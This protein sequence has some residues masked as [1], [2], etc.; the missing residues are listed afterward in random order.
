MV[1]PSFCAL[2]SSVWSS[3]GVG[4]D[5]G[6]YDPSGS[7]SDGICLRVVSRTCASF[8]VDGVASEPTVGGS[9]FLGTDR[10]AA[11]SSSLLPAGVPVTWLADRAFGTPCF[12]DLVTERGWHYVVRVQSQT[13]CQDRQG[14]CLPIGHL[15]SQRGARAKLLGRVFKKRGWRDAS[16]VAYWGRRYESPLCLVSDLPPCWRLIDRYR[17][18]YPIEASFRDYK[19][20]GWRWEQGQVTDLEHLQRLLVGM[21]LATWFALCAGTQVAQEQL[22]KPPTGR[23]RTLPWIGKRS[24]FYLGLQRL[25]QLLYGSES[26]PLAAQLTQWDAPNSQK[27]IFSHHAKA[28]IFA[29]RKAA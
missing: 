17:R 1:F 9:A 14:S 22:S 18:R 12:T 15:V 28:W 11:G 2:P 24:L 19:S 5:L 21:A 16:V 4:V 7:G 26:R 25:G 10:Y 23:R 6:S 3:Q 29:P 8:G 20:L 27:Q 13:R